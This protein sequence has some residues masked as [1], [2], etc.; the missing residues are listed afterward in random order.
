MQK[1]HPTT[2]KMNCSSDRLSQSKYVELPDELA[3]RICG[4]KIPELHKSSDVTLKRGIISTN[5][6]D[7]KFLT[8][9]DLQDE[10]TYI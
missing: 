10:Q 4:G 1:H 2:S 5:Y 9:S 8:A 6:F 3:A 7:G